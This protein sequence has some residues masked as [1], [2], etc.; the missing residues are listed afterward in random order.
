MPRPFFF[1]S[2]VRFIFLLPEASFLRLASF[3]R[4]TLCLS[5]SLSSPSLFDALTTV[6]LSLSSFSAPRSMPRSPAPCFRSYRRGSCSSSSFLLLLPPFPPSFSFSFSFSFAS[7]FRFVSPVFPSLSGSTTDDVRLLCD[8]V[9]DASPRHP[10]ERRSIA[11]ADAFLSS[12][13]AESAGFGQVSRFPPFDPTKIL[14]NRDQRGAWEE[15]KR[16][17]GDGDA[18]FLLE[19]AVLYCY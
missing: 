1:L 19:G 12:N 6:S 13:H 2:L 5:L 11:E 9:A 16:G 17:H 10:L 8:G 4:V 15:R 3:L 7:S 14:R 18:Y